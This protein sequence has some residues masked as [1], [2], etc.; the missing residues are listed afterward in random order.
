MSDPSWNALHRAWSA[1]VGSAGYDKS[2][3]RVMEARLLASRRLGAVE[4]E[5]DV[6]AAADCLRVQQTK[7]KCETSPS[8]SER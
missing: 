2:A 8:K 3:W 6:L 1:A 4:S 7:N 5:A